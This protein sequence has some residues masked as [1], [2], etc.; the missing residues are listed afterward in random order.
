M[1]GVGV[2]VRKKS[3]PGEGQQHMQRPRDGSEGGGAQI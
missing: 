1:G 2:V 3:L